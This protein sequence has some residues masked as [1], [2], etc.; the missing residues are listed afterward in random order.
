MIKNITQEKKFLFQL[1]QMLAEILLI[2]SGK[3]E[4]YVRVLQIFWIRV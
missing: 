1:V 4:T 2:I 3:T